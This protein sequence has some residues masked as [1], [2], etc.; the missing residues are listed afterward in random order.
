MFCQRYKYYRICRYSV[1]CLLIIKRMRIA[2]KQKITMIGLN[3]R[4]LWF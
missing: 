2:N 4:N 1:L 3:H